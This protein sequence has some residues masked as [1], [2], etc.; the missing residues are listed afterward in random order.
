MVVSYGA[1]ERMGASE[2][3]NKDAGGKEQES[4]EVEVSEGMK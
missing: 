1:K 2:G 4:E 3:G